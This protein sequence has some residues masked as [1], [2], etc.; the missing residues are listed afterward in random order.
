MILDSTHSTVSLPNCRKNSTKC[1]AI[2]NGLGGYFG[3]EQSN[4]NTALGPLGS[5]DVLLASDTTEVRV[6][7]TCLVFLQLLAFKET[8]YI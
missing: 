5:S 8:V 3:M 6:L 1:L 4:R 7:F 2:T